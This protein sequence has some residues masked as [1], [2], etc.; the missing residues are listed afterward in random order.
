MTHAAGHI[1]YLEQRM[2]DLSDGDDWLSSAE[3]L[4]LNSFQVAK[5]RSDWRLGR[6]TA[7]R[8]ISAY[9]GWSKE[10]LRDI[11]I[12]S[13]PSG[14]PV[15]TVPGRAVAPEISISHSSNICM[16]VVGAPGI[17]I[18]CDIEKLEIRSQSFIDTFFTPDEGATLQPLSTNEKTTLANVI[19]STKE[20]YL[21][22]TRA[23]LT[24]DTREV[25]TS[26]PAPF[27][28]EIRLAKRGTWLP[29]WI[30]D[31]N[32][33]S[34]GYWRLTA[35]FVESVCHREAPIASIANLSGTRSVCFSSD[36]RT[37]F[38]YLQQRTLNRPTHLLLSPLFACPRP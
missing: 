5:R 14:A 23:G 28:W 21:K 4:I 38:T 13:L 36:Q 20:S 1:F 30:L 18:G 17:W 37:A 35:G 25:N 22:S 33:T 27:K 34:V 6:W 19:W 11:E 29:I 15:A 24:R 3:R 26:L 10:Q 32:M 8:A 9:L 2:T 7:K 12:R 16:C 31:R